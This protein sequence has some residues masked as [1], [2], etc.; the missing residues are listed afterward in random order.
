MNF[1]MIGYGLLGVLCVTYVTLSIIHMTKVNNTIRE[2]SESYKVIEKDVATFTKVSDPKTIRLYVKELNKILDEIHFLGKLIESGE[3]A[4]EGITKILDGHDE[5][6][7][8]ILE[9]VTKEESEMNEQ[10]IYSQLKI[11]QDDVDVILHTID[12]LKLQI[13]RHYMAYTNKVNKIDK[14][15]G[16]I[17]NKLETMNKKRLF[18]THN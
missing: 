3:L 8:K 6:S 16:D 7:Q 1:K 15:I 4:D 13:D 2:W 18:H 9:L 5:L 10:L 17:K 12:D 11:T 14:E